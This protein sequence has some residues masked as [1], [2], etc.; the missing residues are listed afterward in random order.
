[1]AQHADP[2]I[3]EEDYAATAAAIQNMMLAAHGLGLAAF[4]S[5][6]ALISYAP[7]RELLGVAPDRRIVGIV[8]LGY[9]GQQRTGKR[10][11]ATSRTRWLGE[12][13]I[14]AASVEGDY[15]ARLVSSQ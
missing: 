4:W 8:Q 12:P 14:S 7:A 15:V 2:A 11:P 3:R 13:R 9:A 6:N 1:M 5:T 10:A